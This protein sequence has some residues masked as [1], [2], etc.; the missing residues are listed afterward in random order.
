[1]YLVSVNMITIVVCRMFPSLYCIKLSHWCIICCG[2]CCRLLTS[3]SCVCIDLF[4]ELFHRKLG[5][6]PGL[7]IL[8]TLNSAHSRD[9]STRNQSQTSLATLAWL[10]STAAT[11][12]SWVRMTSWPL[13]VAHLTR[14]SYDCRCGRV[15]VPVCKHWSSVVENWSIWRRGT[16]THLCE[17]V[18][19]GRPATPAEHS[20]VHMKH[21]DC[22]RH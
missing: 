13:L 17:Y 11:A 10:L 3:D 21:T 5:I 15:L 18:A 4:T 9:Q 19:V 20:V 14:Q 1:M 6:W 7:Q 2:T 16:N 12:I 8:R 22:F